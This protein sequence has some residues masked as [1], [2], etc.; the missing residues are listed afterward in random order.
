MRRMNTGLVL[1]AMV[2]F[3]LVAGLGVILYRDFHQE[4]TQTVDIWYVENITDPYT[5]MGE[6]IQVTYDDRL[7]GHKVLLFEKNDLS[8]TLESGKYRLTYDTTDKLWKK[9]KPWILREAVRV[10]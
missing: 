1:S 3:T 4:K 8:T 9:T 6:V 5:G 7:L 10:E 2:L